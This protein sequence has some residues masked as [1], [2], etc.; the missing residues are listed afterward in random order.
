VTPEPTI[1]ITG[2]AGTLGRA[3]TPVLAEHGY[4]VRAMD[5][6]PTDFGLPSVSAIAGDIRRPDDVRRAVAGVDAVVH[7]AAWHGIHLREH[8]ARDF[9]ELNVDGTFNVYEAAA[10][11][12]VG[13][14]VFSSTMGVYG[15]SRE[16]ADGRA[17]HVHEDSPRLPTD[18]YGLSKGLGEDLAACYARTGRVRSVALRF[19]MFVPEPFARYG[20]RLLYGGVD[21]RDVASAVMAAL[22]A[23]ESEKL[24]FD[25]FNIESA[26]PFT[27]FEAGELWNDPAAVVSHHWPHAP[28]LMR[29]VGAELWGPIK[30][31]FDIAKAG[32]VL[33]WRP[34]HNFDAF[35]DA[36]RSQP[37]AMDPVESDDRR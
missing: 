24:E 8:P 4:A 10:E 27:E 2:A 5:L 11:A 29:A 17:V 3:L 26:L 31:W 33:G 16:S 19:G 21:E 28:E 14:V 6:A 35:L 18:V 1:L 12:G 9:W 30:E 37:R 22:Q 34:Q 36:I 25:A 13:K 20:V 32:Q 7:A 23:L 15:R